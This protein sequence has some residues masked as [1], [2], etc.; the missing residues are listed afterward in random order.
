M[1]QRPRRRALHVARTVEHDGQ[2]MRLRRF[3]LA[4]PYPRTR[5][6]RPPRRTRRHPSRVRRRELCL[7][8]RT[9]VRAF[10]HVAVIALFARW[11]AAATS[12]GIPYTHEKNERPTSKGITEEATKIADARVRHALAPLVRAVRTVENARLAYSY[13]PLRGR[14][15]Y[16]RALDSFD[17]FVCSTRFSYLYTCT[18]KKRAR[19]DDDGCLPPSPPVLGFMRTICRTL[20]FLGCARALMRALPAC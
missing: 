17:S 12:S 5:R 19:Q 2:R 1:Y 10:E 4:S 14:P 6:S 9:P 3:P 15:G 18:E 8:E 11:Y 20:S 7:D 13:S 16:D